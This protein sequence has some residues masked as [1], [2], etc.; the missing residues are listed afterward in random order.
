MLLTCVKAAQRCRS[1]EWDGV[2]NRKSILGKGASRWCS[3]FSFKQHLLRCCGSCFQAA[4][5]AWWRRGSNR[6]SEGGGM[7]C[8]LLVYHVMW[9]IFFNS[10]P[11][12]KPLTQRRLKGGWE[13]IERTGGLFQVL[14]SWSLCMIKH[15]LCCSWSLLYYSCSLCKHQLISHNELISRPAVYFIVSK[16]V[17]YKCT[18]CSDSLLLSRHSF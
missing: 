12:K 2:C 13:T 1:M 15:Q 16:P 5:A 14:S 3:W 6:M 7:H 18:I 8:V 10:V 9:R 11:E 17:L 4:W